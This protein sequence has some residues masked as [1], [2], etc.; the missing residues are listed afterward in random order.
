VTMTS[1]VGNATSDEGSSIRRAE[2][3]SL[4]LLYAIM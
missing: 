1:R 2:T 3:C 4:H